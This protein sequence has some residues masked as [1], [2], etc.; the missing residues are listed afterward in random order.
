MGVFGQ[1][2]RFEQRWAAYAPKKFN[3]RIVMA[4]EAACFSTPC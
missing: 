4:G 1:K 3:G 2:C